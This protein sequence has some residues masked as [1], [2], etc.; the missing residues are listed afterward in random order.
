MKLIRRGWRRFAS[1]FTY[2]RLLIGWMIWNASFAGF[3]MAAMVIDLV[4]HAGAFYV[5]YE[6]AMGI[7]ML[8]MWVF[9]VYVYNDY[10][11]REARSR[12]LKRLERILP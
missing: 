3:D 4:T 1:L 5:I 12:I 6:F 11:D 10:M 2:K 9:S 7:F 8:A